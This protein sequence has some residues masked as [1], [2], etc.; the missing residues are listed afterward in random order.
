MKTDE[1]IKKA[2]KCIV[3]GFVLSKEKDLLYTKP[4]FIWSSMF[5]LIYQLSSNITFDDEE[6][7][8]QNL[9]KTQTYAAIEYE[10]IKEFKLLPVLRIGGMPYQTHL[11]EL[12]IKT[13]TLDLQIESREHQDILSLCRIV[14]HMNIE[15]QDPCDVIKAL[16]YTQKEESGYYDY[17]MEHYTNIAKKHQLDIPRISVYRKGYYNNT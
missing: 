11:I 6:M 15:I 17:M 16:L 7:I 12:Y 4:S 8:F 5:T 9:Q 13:D 2:K 14:H 1:F 3:Y 10:D